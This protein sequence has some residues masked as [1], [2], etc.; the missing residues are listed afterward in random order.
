MP[1]AF[2]FALWVFSDYDNHRHHSDLPI[3]SGTFSTIFLWFVDV[4][5]SRIECEEF[6]AAEAKRAVF[7]TTM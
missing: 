3:Y 1:F 5:K 6:V 4:P 7:E 2:L